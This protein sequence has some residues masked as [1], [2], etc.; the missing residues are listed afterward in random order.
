MFLI[1]GGLILTS[2]VGYYNRS[3]IFSF[4]FKITLFSVLNCIK[5]YSFIYKKK[6]NKINKIK[7]QKIRDLYIEEYEIYLNGKKHDTVLIANS[8]IILTENFNE[9]MPN[10]SNKLQNKNIIV[11]CNIIN[12]NGDVVIELTNIFRKFFYY[13]DKQDFKL[14]MFFD[15]V[16]AYCDE[17]DDMY[18]GINIYEYDF[19]VY[20]NDDSFTELGYKINYIKEKSINDILIKNDL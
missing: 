2:I 15:Y 12:E 6:N 7:Y 17:K 8:S 20:L 19:I 11:Y 9:L 16:Q 13:F 10:I 18:N 5:L 14:K 3:Y 1:F 4:V